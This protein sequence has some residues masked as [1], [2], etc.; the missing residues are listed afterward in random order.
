MTSN[1]KKEVQAIKLYNIKQYTFIKMTSNYIMAVQIIKLKNI[2]N[3]L[4][5]AK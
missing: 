3:K 4:S 5:Y 1:Y 2:I